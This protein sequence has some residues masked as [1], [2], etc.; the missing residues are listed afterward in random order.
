[1]AERTPP[2][3]PRPRVL[4][5]LA[6]LTTAALFGAASFTDPGAVSTKERTGWDGIVH[7]TVE[8]LTDGEWVAQLR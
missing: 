3:D 1:M 5:A 8:I 7:A 2:N 6:V 4:L